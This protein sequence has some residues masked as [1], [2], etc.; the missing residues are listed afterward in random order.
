PRG[1]KL[2]DLDADRERASAEATR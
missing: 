1:I 2:E